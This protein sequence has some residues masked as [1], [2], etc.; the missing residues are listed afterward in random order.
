MYCERISIQFEYYFTQKTQ[1]SLGRISFASL[2]SKKWN[3]IVRKGLNFKAFWVLA[4]NQKVRITQLLFFIRVL[5]QLVSG[6]SDEWIK[7]RIFLVLKSTKLVKF[8]L[9]ASCWWRK[10]FLPQKFMVFIYK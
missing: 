8:F 1:N 6:R 4:V 10:F 5:H 7:T 2:C 3:K 9:C